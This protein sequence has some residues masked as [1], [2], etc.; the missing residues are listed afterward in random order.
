MLP[1]KVKGNKKVFSGYWAIHV[2]QKIKCVNAKLSDCTIED[3]NLEDVKKIVLDKKILK[4]IPLKK[5]LV[6]R[7]KEDFSYQLYH[8]SIVEAIMTVNPEGIG[9]TNIEEWNEG[10]FF[11]K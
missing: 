1:A 11:E 5:R 10:S 4:A 2:Y 7:L 6:F 8:A 9:F 3:I